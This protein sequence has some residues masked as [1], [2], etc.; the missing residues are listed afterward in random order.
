MTFHDLRMA[1]RQAQRTV[2]LTSINLIGLALGLAV[3]VL[4]VL[5][6]RYES[7]YD[8][9]HADSD[10]LY[11]VVTPTEV[12]TPIPL[13]PTLAAVDPRVTDATRIL[14]T[15]GDVLIKN[16]VEESYYES[17]FYFV[18]STF[19]DIFGAP[20]M[21]G[22]PETALS[23]KNSLVISER[24]AQKYFGDTDP[25]G[26]ILVFDVGFEAEMRIT[27]VL[28]NPPRNA[29]VQ[30]DF[31][32]SM[33]TFEDFGFIDFDDWNHALMHTYVRLAP[34][35][36]GAAITRDLSSTL[37]SHTEADLSNLQL[38]PITAIH[39]DD[40]RRGGFEAPG[41]RTTL[42]TFSFIAVL[43]L[44]IACIN[45]MN[46][47][48]AR[49]AHRAYE[50]GMRK[51]LGASRGLLVRQFYSEALVHTLLAALLAL[52][53]AYGGM[54]LLNRAFDMELAVPLASWGTGVFVLASGVAFVTLLVGSYPAFVLSRFAPISMM[55]KGTPLQG[56][57]RS[58]RQVLVVAQFGIGFI[59]LV[60]S[61]VAREQLQF[62]QTEHVGFAQE[63]MVVL[64]ARTYGHATTP[65]PF[66]AMRN[67]FLKHPQVEAVAV[68]GDVP[69]ER[70]RTS[71]FRPEGFV[72]LEQLPTLEWSR[73]DIDYDFVETLD[74]E[75]MAGRAFDRDRP[76]DAKGMVLINETAWREI[77]RLVG[78]AWDDPL[79]KSLDRYLAF[80]GE[81][82]LARQGQV[83]GVVRDFHYESLHHPIAPLVLQLNTARYDHF[84]LRVRL[85]D[86]PQLLAD[87][88]AQWQAFMPERPFEYRFLDAAFGA[89]YQTD[90][91]IAQLF[92]AFA[93][94]SLGIAALG[95]L[96]LTLFTTTQRTRE[97]GIRQVLGAFPGQLVW[98]L[99]RD[100]LRLV[101]IGCVVA[102]PLAY[103]A[104]SIWL[105]TF[106][107]HAAVQPVPFVLAATIV[108][109][110]ATA[111]I[112][113]QTL[114]I[115]RSNPAEALRHI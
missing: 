19:W 9:F 27:G 44:L 42:Y 62:L 102:V 13:G 95:L 33:V 68:T 39:L 97:I 46:L 79:G 64:S 81:W 57:H 45:F 98:L 113:W 14:M 34:G 87:L 21:R 105:A 48:T 29:H 84:V 74:L 75:L 50:V 55:H 23:T 85:D 51:V 110:V 61:L 91:R 88:E 80:D 103:I 114:R 107:Y 28:A 24:M 12:V 86:V 111:T 6:V 43:V 99:S 100:V 63:Q 101:A 2:L 15:L 37:A 4:I 92:N 112:L 115:A 96:G 72:D 109:V 18:D 83:L 67:E 65:I 54:R 1:W 76:G 49:A 104:V 89:Q 93:L 16:T 36:T 66:E 70:P 7:T 108:L 35:Q 32:G 38:Q 17:R 73:F 58:I 22:N 52:P 8:R 30:P 60:G 82:L 77:Q 20:L 69:G 31:L 90:R 59:L 47:A 5:Y 11:R 78:D 53:L 41:S 25:I 94:L 10:Q 3:C 106:A 26:Q 40:E 56:P 71:V